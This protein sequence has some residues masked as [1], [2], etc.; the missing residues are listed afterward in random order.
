[1]DLKNE[2]KSVIDCL[3]YIIKTVGI[4][5]DINKDIIKM[6]NEQNILHKQG[7]RI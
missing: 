1:M 7:E 3:E 6:L 4:Q 5:Q 2:K